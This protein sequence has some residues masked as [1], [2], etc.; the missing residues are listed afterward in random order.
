MTDTAT[1]LLPDGKAV[2]AAPVVCDL[3]AGGLELR[4]TLPPGRGLAAAGLRIAAPAE[5]AANSRPCI[6]ALSSDRGAFPGDGKEVAWLRASWPQERAIAGIRL[7]G[8]GPDAGAARLRVFSRGIWRPLTPPDMVMLAAEKEARIMSLT[9]VAA[10]AVMAEFQG[11]FTPVAGAPPVFVPAARAVSGMTVFGTDQP[12]H[13]AVSVGADPAFFLCEGPL[14]AAPVV[15]EGLLRAVGRYLADNANP[16]E[17]PL[18]VTSAARGQ[19]ILQDFA[20]SLRP[21]VDRDDGAGTKPGPPVETMVP[22]IGSP[23]AGTAQLCDAAHLV[24]QRLEPPFCDATIASL[25]LY[26]A[27]G[28]G[29]ALGTVALHG[30]AER[31]DPQPFAEQPETSL[32]MPLDAAPG[33][34]TCR[35][36]QP[37]KPGDPAWVVCRITSGE[38]FWFTASAERPKGFGPLLTSSGGG[39][40]VSVAAGWAYL[41]LGVVPGS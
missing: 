16:A 33:W 11:S 19:I 15:V 14:P 30:G 28:A 39:P 34:A 4:L 8:E 37:W 31:P 21:P 23:D 40:W 5:E 38:A 26:M 17:I 6:A 9:P 32:P 27:A 25:G 10:A 18:R 1:L 22:D 20:A 7:Q 36:Q 13:V 41:R 3:P 2:G 35:L 24:A 12:C 29:P